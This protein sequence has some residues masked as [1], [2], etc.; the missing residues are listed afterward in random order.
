[1][2]KQLYEKAKTI[3]ETTDANLGGAFIQVTKHLDVQDVET[4]V[5]EIGS[6]RLSRIMER[7][8]TNETLAEMRSSIEMH[9]RGMA[10][11]RGDSL[12]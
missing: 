2:L 1:M 8:W 10:L 4:C 5:R 6:K 9:L 12:R 7:G 11:E 3:T